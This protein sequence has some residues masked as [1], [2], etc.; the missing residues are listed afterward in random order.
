MIKLSGVTKTY[1]MGDSEYKALK[2]IDLHVKEGDFTAI[3]GASGSG[4]TTTMNILGLL[5][6]PTSGEY[7]L[8]GRDTTSLTANDQARWRNHHIGFIFQSFF[9]LPRLSA[10]EN[11]GLPLLYR[12]ED[13][14]L[15]EKRSMQMLKKVHMDK[16]ARHRPT[17]L[18]GGQ[19]QRV[20]IARALVGRP[21]IILADEPTGAL[22]TQTSNDVM[23]ILIN[24]NK[25]EGATIIIITHDP[26]IAEQCTNVVKISDGLIE[27]K[28]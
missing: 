22:D 2:G 6:H 7:L 19:Q 20:A 25:K 1:V 14:R 11:V 4:K 28:E 21:N 27:S 17:E 18:S 23:D 10:I 16:H 15:V 26:G 5:D 9:L 3:I 13:R 12:G 24:L 8:N